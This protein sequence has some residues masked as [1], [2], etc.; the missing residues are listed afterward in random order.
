[1]DSSMRASGSSI[2][3]INDNTPILTSTIGVYRHPTRPSRIKIKNF[4]SRQLALE[5]PI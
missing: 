1:M 4:Y 5:K 2:I 3:L